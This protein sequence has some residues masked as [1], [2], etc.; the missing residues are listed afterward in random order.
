MKLLLRLVLIFVLTLGLSASAYAE[1]PSICKGRIT[2]VT[3]PFNVN[4]GVTS[5]NSHQGPGLEDNEAVDLSVI[6]LEAGLAPSTRDLAACA[7]EESGDYDIYLRNNTAYDFALRGWAWNTNLGFLSLS[8]IDGVNRSGRDAVACGDTD[9][10]VYIGPEVDDRRK[11]FGHAWSPSFGWVQFADDIRD[12]PYDPVI[13]SPVEYNVWRDA[14]GNL[15]GHA[16]TEAGV[17]MDMDGV[18]IELSQFLEKEE[19]PEEEIGES[20]CEGRPFLCVEVGPHPAIVPFLAPEIDVALRLGLEAYYPAENRLVPLAEVPQEDIDSGLAL[21]AED[22]VRV[23]DGIDGYEINLF[24][25][26]EDGNDIDPANYFNYD[27]FLRGIEFHWI[28]SVKLDQTGE[29]N[30]DDDFNAM[31]RPFRESGGRAGVIFKPKRLYNDGELEGFEQVSAS[32]FKTTD[33][34]D[35][36]PGAN[37]KRY[38][39][40]RSHAPTSE[41]NISYTTS[42]EPVYT[43]PNEIFL[44]DIGVVPP[45]K[46]QLILEYVEFSVPLL[47]GDEDVEIV[48]A[49]GRVLPNGKVGMPFRF[50]PAIEVSTLYADDKKDVLTA[51]RSL[52][53]NLSVQSSLLSTNDEFWD[54]LSIGGD[55]QAPNTTFKLAYS[56]EATQSESGCGGE[57]FDFHFLRDF[58]DQEIE[59]SVSELEIS[60]GVLR[61]IRTIQAVAELMVPEPVGGG[62]EGEEGEEDDLP[63]AELPCSIA[64]APSVYSLIEYY[65]G[66]EGNRHQVRYYSNKL[67]RIAGNNISNPFVVVHGNIYGQTEANVTSQVSV[68]TSGS[69]D[70]NIV[71]DTINENLARNAGDLVDLAGGRSCTLSTLNLD[72]QGDCRVGTDYQPM[73]VGEEKVLYFKNTNVTLALADGWAGDWVIVSD[74][75]NIFIDQDL[76]DGEDSDD[77]LVLLTFR[78]SDPAKYQATGNIY[79]GPCTLGANNLNNIQAILVADGSVFS[80]NGDRV[81]GIDFEGDAPTGE[82]QWGQ[83]EDRVAALNCQLLIEGAVFSDNTIGGADLDRAVDAEGDLVNKEYLLAGGGEVLLP[84]VGREGF[85]DVQRARAQSFDLNYLRL[86]KLEVELDVGGLPI[87]QNCGMSLTAEDIRAIYLFDNSQVR[88]GYEHPPLCGEVQPCEVPDPNDD[89]IYPVGRGNASLLRNRCNGINI[90]K[91]FDEDE[92]DG[93]NDAK[94]D[95]IV[96]RNLGNL[97]RGLDNDPQDPEA[98]HF[99]PIYV[100]YDESAEKSFV[101]SKDG[102]LKISGR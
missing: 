72:N 9:Y 44:E 80:Y 57:R 35:L 12:G 63:P 47:A 31:L 4:A 88:G 85:T 68:Q 27:E 96:P 28:D 59:G 29:H 8:C 22:L 33:D 43:V 89:G 2:G 51:Y 48:L 101:F 79:L 20:W 45:E 46:S 92:R 84:L 36:S 58:W 13:G 67:P 94:G 40:I 3:D 71:R 86:F 49:P 76:Y 90:F 95:L 23:A 74:G 26:D 53:M 73:E 38:G 52:P 34:V 10:G 69:V 81:E 18:N 17:W 55:G 39:P 60:P 65:I 19:E 14:A 98:K 82:P 91:R 16:W 56:E 37:P 62:E 102:A 100:F 75:G 15:S 32:H 25:R 64:K 30:I 87:D 11:V 61:V 97:A 24:M 54:S 70:V 21:T 6:G 83:G 93:S 66:T 7:E 78:D 50:R 1:G 5:F 41:T 77:S 99:D 42:T